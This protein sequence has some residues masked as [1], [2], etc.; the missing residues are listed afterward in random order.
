MM[1]LFMQSNRCQDMPSRSLVW[2]LRMAVLIAG[3]FLLSG[4]TTAQVK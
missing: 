1:E 3:L 4:P 2:L